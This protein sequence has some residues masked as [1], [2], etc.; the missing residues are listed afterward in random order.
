MTKSIFYQLDLADAA[1]E[2]V[3]GGIMLPKGFTSGCSA[4]ETCMTICFCARVLQLSGDER[5]HGGTAAGILA[6]A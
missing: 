4:D 3:A 6:V 5:G 2:F 1:S